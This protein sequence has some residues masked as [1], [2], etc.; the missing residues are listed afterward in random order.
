MKTLIIILSLSFFSVLICYGQN[1]NS[2]P[3]RNDQKPE[4]SCKVKVENKSVTL[5]NI[6]A[7]TLSYEELISCRELRVSNDQTSVAGEGKKTIVSFSLFII[8]EESNSMMEF[9]GS[10][11]QL[12]EEMVSKI[13]EVKAKK[14]MLGEILSWD[15]ANHEYLGHRSFYFK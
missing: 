4:K 13:I 5:C 3:V 8:L 10:G 12:T 11:N 1:S 9:L 6:K 7:D 14:I 2:A 15:G